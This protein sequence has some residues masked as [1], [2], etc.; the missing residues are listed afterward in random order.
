[1]TWTAA[2]GDS[3]SA[4][5]S[6][7]V[8]VYSG[9]SVTDNPVHTITT[10]LLTATFSNLLDANTSYTVVVSAIDE[11][12]DN[13]T[14]SAPLAS[15]SVTFKSAQATLVLPPI[16]AILNPTS[17]SATVTWLPATGD[18][19]G[20]I[21]YYVSVSSNATISVGNTV[22]PNGIVP[23]S[24]VNLSGLNPNEKY[25]VTVQAVDKYSS[26][27]PS[28]LTTCPTSN[29]AC[30]TVTFTTAA[31]PAITAP[32]TPVISS[33]T[34][35]SAIVTWAAS[36][37]DSDTSNIVY[38]VSFSQGNS[39]GV[40]A[41]MIPGSSPPSATLSGLT[42]SMQY[43]ISIIAYDGSSSNK[44]TMSQQSASFTTQAHLVAPVITS[45]ENSATISTPT[46]ASITWNAAT[47]DTSSNVG[48]TANIYAGNSATGKPISTVPV[49]AGATSAAF[50]NLSA[51]TQYTVTVTA[52]DTNADN[53]P[54]SDP[55]TFT[56]SKPTITAPQSL[57]ANSITQTS[58]IVSWAASTVV[59]DS[60]KH[61]KYRVSVAS[62]G[63]D[64]TNSV[65]VHQK[66]F[67]AA[68]GNWSVKISHLNMNTPYEVY[69]T[70]KDRHAR[71][72]SMKSDGVSFTTQ[73]VITPPQSLAITPDSTTAADATVTWDTATGD[74]NISY[75]VTVSPNA[76]VHYSGGLSAT[77]SGLT[78]STK[79]TVSVSAGAA[80]ASNSNTPQTTAS[81]SY[82][83]IAKPQSLAVPAATITA[84]GATVTWDAVANIAYQVTIS[85]DATVTMNSD[86]SSAA[87]SELTESTPYTVSVKAQDSDAVNSPQTSTVDFTTKAVIT[88]PQSLVVTPSSTTPGDATVTWGVATGDSDTTNITYQVTISPNAPVNYSSG[89]SATLSGLTTGTQYTV[90]VTANDPNAFPATTQASK[91][92][93]PQAI[94]SAPG[95]PVASNVTSNSATV[96]WTAP[97]VGNNA[98]V[99]YVPSVTPNATMNYSSGLSATLS[100]LSPHT[101]YSVTVKAVDSII[102][103]SSKSHS[104]KFTTLQPDIQFPTPCTFASSMNR[105]NGT[106]TINPVMANGQVVKGVTYSIQI[107]GPGSINVKVIP[108]S[109]VDITTAKLRTMVPG[110][111]YTAMVSAEYNGKTAQTTCA[112]PAN[113]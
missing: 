62:G 22:V 55:V 66:Q 102:G 97:S 8:A 110:K 76:T 18:D 24:P 109:G 75:Q 100:G 9:S 106:L 63:N 104:G 61:V 1:M 81:V 52:N 73:S 31:G 35:D 49:T 108:N 25:T 7:S 56:T 40:A 37:G 111:A 95:I 38:S 50:S 89:L 112:I 68:T 77:L 87:L 23:A 113:R 10:S 72:S 83:F 12:S 14:S 36:T 80:N 79:Y 98:N 11:N 2:T 46:S 105:H 58:A 6:Y 20:N 27:S 67:N 47:G 60:A 96:S 65:W 78:A 69:I 86:G 88:A 44:T 15:N 34:S 53:S 99:T 41:P 5:I 107:T 54:V 85:P 84:T 82:I 71:P 43:T 51:N 90:T 74:A 26:N 13:A 103:A 70:A 57:A 28:A 29:S 59:G 101:A 33:I 30:Q 45:P 92:F 48:Y 16:P 94:L 21:T 64:V 19:P 91:S 4:N 32:G 3:K 93:T 39:K 42:P 17:S